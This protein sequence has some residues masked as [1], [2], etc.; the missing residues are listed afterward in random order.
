MSKVQV[1]KHFEQVG[2]RKLECGLR[3]DGV[4]LPL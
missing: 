4:D 2:V 1:D 3:C